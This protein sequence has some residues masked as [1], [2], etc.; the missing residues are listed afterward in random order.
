[1]KVYV[2]LHHKG[3]LI[4]DYCGISATLEGAKEIIQGILD[5]G[6]EDKQLS[7]CAQFEY[8]SYWVF[9][10]DYERFEIWEEVIQRNVKEEE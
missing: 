8:D 10:I 6:F 2:V 5:E 4:Y 7:S 3:S 1:M 9:I